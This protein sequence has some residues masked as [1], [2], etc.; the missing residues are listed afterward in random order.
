MFRETRMIIND[1]EVQATL[2]GAGEHEADSS[3]PILTS[4]FAFDREH[5]ARSSVLPTASP[6]LFC[7]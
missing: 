2:L 6:I 5:D 4:V 7:S 1:L 3:L